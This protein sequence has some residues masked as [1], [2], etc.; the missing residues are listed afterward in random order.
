MARFER[1]KDESVFFSLLPGLLKFSINIMSIATMINPIPTVLK[2]VT[3][4]V[5]RYMANLL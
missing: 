3:K 4:S 1:E 2:C 5:R